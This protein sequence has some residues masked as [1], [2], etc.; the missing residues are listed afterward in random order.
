MRGFFKDNFP[1]LGEYFHPAQDC[2]Q[3]AQ[4]SSD[5]K[6]GFYWI[7]TTGSQKVRKVCRSGQ[8]YI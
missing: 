4:K 1:S 8:H 6:D 2:F 7:K 5:V 3:I